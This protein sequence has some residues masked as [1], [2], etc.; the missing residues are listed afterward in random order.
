MSAATPFPSPL[1]NVETELRRLFENAPFGVAH[2]GRQGTIAAINPALEQMVGGRDRIAKCFCASDLIDPQGQG[3]S[4][5]L[6]RELFDGERAPM[7]IG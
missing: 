5:R 6:F 4:R 3:E 2:C 7:K 1:G